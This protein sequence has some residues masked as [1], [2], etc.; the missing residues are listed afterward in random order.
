MRNYLPAA[1]LILIPISAVAT[2]AAWS[3]HFAKSGSISLLAILPA[4][5]MSVLTNAAFAA[6]Y[7]ILNRVASRELVFI[8]GAAHLG[9]SFLWLLLRAYLRFLTQQSLAAEERI[10]LSATFTWSMIAAVLAAAATLAFFAAMIV[11]LQDTRRRKN[12]QTFD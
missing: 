2:F 7:A 9:C 6:L 4:I 3:P 8:L 5:A 10:D 1:W 11:A 12:L